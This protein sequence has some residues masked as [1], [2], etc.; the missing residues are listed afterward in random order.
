MKNK[1]Y[2]YPILYT[3]RRCPYAI[4]AR[5]ALSYSKINV[6]LKEI[7]LSNRPP[8]LYAISTKG[9]VPVLYINN[10]DVIDE[11]LDIMKWA[12]NQN[13]PN[14]WISY[15]KRMQFDI[16]EENDNEFKY[17][18]DR[19]KYFDRFPENNKDYYRH[20]CGKF[21]KKLNQLLEFNQYLLTDKVIAEN[22]QATGVESRHSVGLGLRVEGAAAWEEKIDNRIGRIDEL[23]TREA[24]RLKLL[25]DKEVLPEGAPEQEGYLS[26]TSSA[27]V[28]IAGGKRKSH[29][30]SRKKFRKKSH[31][32]KR[33]SRRKKRSKTKICS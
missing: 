18:L 26:Y 4:R 13:D 8:E 7:L 33:K 3:F 30:K 2:T 15:N 19:Y 6:E 32:K 28:K 1:N 16:I 31:K 21:L 24:D 12:L 25:E 10:T 9:T 14:L 23:I 5:M 17:W 27:P 11:S 20:K 22:M 29:K